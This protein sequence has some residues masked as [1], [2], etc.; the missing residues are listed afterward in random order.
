MSQFQLYECQLL[1]KSQFH[2]NL[3]LTKRCSSA[4]YPC[5]TPV[6]QEDVFTP[7]PTR[8]HQPS[9]LQELES[10]ASPSFSTPITLSSSKRS[11]TIIH[12]T[13]DRCHEANQVNPCLVDHAANMA[14]TNERRMDIE[15]A[16][17]VDNIEELCQEV[18]HL[19]VAQ[20][21]YSSFPLNKMKDF[22][23]GGI[24]ESSDTFIYV[25]GKVIDN[26][27]GYVAICVSKLIVS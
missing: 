9:P 11:A 23:P 17:L 5:R 19:S 6:F 12:S 8:T 27:G 24:R 21:L 13:Y 18:S 22:Y 4:W 3:T 10:T 15:D 1:S 2:S 25:P 7:F 26:A 16:I 20:I 14:W